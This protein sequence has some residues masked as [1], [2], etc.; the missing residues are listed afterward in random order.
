[1]AAAT[2]AGAILTWATTLSGIDLSEYG[3]GAEAALFF[4]GS[5]V[6]YVG[7]RSLAKYVHPF[8]EH[9]LIVPKAPKY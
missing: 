4:L 5:L 2:A 9:F 8:F 7:V 3:D 6:Y 1:M